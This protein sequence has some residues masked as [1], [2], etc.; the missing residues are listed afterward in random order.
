MHTF[1]DTGRLIGAITRGPPNWFRVQFFTVAVVVLTVPDLVRYI[2]S[3][4]DA[5]AEVSS[6]Y[7]LFCARLDQRARKDGAILNAGEFAG[8]ALEE[9]Q[10][11][12]NDPAD[13]ENDDD[14]EGD[15]DA[16]SDERMMGGDP[17][18][19]NG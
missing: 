7:Y 15:D 4:R 18:E 13:G 1:V 6:I 10:E 16:C 3:G 9:S 12:S 17:G 2:D 19:A 5:R 14:K 11:R 8:C